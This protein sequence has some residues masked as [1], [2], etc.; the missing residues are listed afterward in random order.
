MPRPP[1]SVIEVFSHPFPCVL[2]FVRSH[3]VVSSRFVMLVLQTLG[4]LNDMQEVFSGIVNPKRQE[5]DY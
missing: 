3:F 4:I 2:S 5:L 1:Q